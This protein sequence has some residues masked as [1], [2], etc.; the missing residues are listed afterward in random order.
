[1]TMRIL[2]GTGRMQAQQ[3][4]TFPSLRLQLGNQH[5]CGTPS[6]TGA[7]S[8]RCRLPLVHP[9]SVWKDSLS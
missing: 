9:G 4:V 5:P 1:M 6:N 3:T 8:S 7:A 2:L